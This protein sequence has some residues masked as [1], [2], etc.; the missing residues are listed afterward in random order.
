MYT[1]ISNRQDEAERWRCDEMELSASSFNDLSDEEILLK[2]DARKLG[3]CA[4]ALVNSIV[5][6]A[7]PMTMVTVP[8]PKIVDIAPITLSIEDGEIVKSVVSGSIPSYSLESRL[9]DCHR[10]AAIW[11]E[12]V[13]RRL[14][15]IPLAVHQTCSRRLAVVR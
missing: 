4:A 7:A 12:A 13:Q 3:P 14:L 5:M 11:R 1:K 10:R 2:E 15:Q 6:A 8:S 9:G